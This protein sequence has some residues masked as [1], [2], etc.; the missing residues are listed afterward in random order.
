[1]AVRV[2][3]FNV[4]NLFARFKFS[5][6]VEPHEASKNGWTVD[7]TV[8]HPLS[9][10]DK[11]LTGAAVQ[12]IDADILC[13]QEVESVDTLKHFRAR[14]LGGSKAYPY[15]AGIDGNDP[16]LIDVAVLSRL[17]ITHVRSYQHL[18]DPAQPSREVFSRDCLE[19]DLQWPGPGQTLTVFVQ[20][21]KSMMG[22]RAQTAQR[23]RTQ[24]EAVKRI[25]EDRFGPDPGDHPFLVC[26][27]LNDYLQ[28]DEQGEPAIGELVEWD[29]VVNVVDRL[30][31]DERWTHYYKA[32]KHY[33]QLD[34]LLLSRSLADANPAVPQIMRK[35]LPLR[36]ERYTGERFNGVG[37][38]H[39][40]ASDHCPVV[41]ALH[42]PDEPQG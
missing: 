32:R 17:P 28:A 21:F 1:M 4:E 18:R 22:G 24:A 2:A 30:P 27:D 6:G 34:Y 20:H 10:T 5:S 35:G 11:A 40:K 23:R 39:P 9:M 31:E 14:A 16:R 13:L 8:F 7:E 33:T 37:R 38:D 26:G 3:T 29:Q 25:V 41:M 36:A 19:V 15:V 42:H 12:E